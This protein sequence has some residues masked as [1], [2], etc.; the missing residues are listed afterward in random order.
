[1]NDNLTRALD[2]YR[3]MLHQNFKHVIKNTPMKT[4]TITGTAQLGFM[5]AGRLAEACSKKASGPCGS[6]VGFLCWTLMSSNT[7][8]QWWILVRCFCISISFLWSS[9]LNSDMSCVTRYIHTYRKKQ[10]VCFDHYNRGEKVWGLTLVRRSHSKQ[11]YL[12]RD[13]AKWNPPLSP[14]AL[15]S[16]LTA[17]ASFEE[18]S[19]R[20]VWLRQETSVCTGQPL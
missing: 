20:S 4:R 13:E 3:P 16:V 5:G 15:V 19:I 12:M 2:L 10:A 14:P 17:G 8:C 11:G 18:K 6:S 9:F 1:M 7:C